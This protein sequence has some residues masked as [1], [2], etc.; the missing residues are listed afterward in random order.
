[1]GGM[2]DTAN[3]NGFTV[4]LLLYGDYPKLATRCLGSIIAAMDAEL[5]ISLRIAANAISFFIGNSP[6]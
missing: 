5:V 4:G 3:G 2:Q 1:M 6:A